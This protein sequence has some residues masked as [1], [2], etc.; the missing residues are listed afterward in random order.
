MF[1]QI[2]R[3]IVDIWKSKLIY[4]ILFLAIDLIKVY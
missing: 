4:N 2:R 3:V 1:N